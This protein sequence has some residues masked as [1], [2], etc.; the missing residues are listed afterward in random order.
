MSEEAKS[1]VPYEQTHKLRPLLFVT[2]IMPEGQSDYAVELNYECEAAL[3]FVCRGQG[4][5]PA[6]M[7]SALSIGI[8]KKDVVFSILR[9]DCWEKYKAAISKRFAVSR[10][11]KGI[12][13]SIPLDSVAGVS[14]YKM[15]SNTRLFEKPISASGKKGKKHE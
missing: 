12:A 8:T 1:F 14:I 10:M 3:C 7:L 15:L 4:T 5:A 13:Y 6:D 2:T 11:A 9:L